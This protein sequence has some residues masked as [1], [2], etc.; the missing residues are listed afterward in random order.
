MQKVEPWEELKSEADM[1]YYY[2]EKNASKQSIEALFNSKS[3]D[4]PDINV[5]SDAVSNY[6]NEGKKEP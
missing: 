2:W 1:E 6:M 4:I 5:Y 3:E